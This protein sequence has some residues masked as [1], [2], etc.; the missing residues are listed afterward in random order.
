MWRNG[1]LFRSSSETWPVGG[2]FVGV[3]MQTTRTR[4]QLPAETLGPR[5]RAGAGVGARRIARTIL[6]HL[7]RNR[8]YDFLHALMYFVYAHG[9]LPRRSS[10]LLNDYLFFMK[11][12]GALADPLRQITTDKIYAKYFIDGLAG[13]KVTPETYAVFDS[14]EEIRPGDLPYRCVLKPAHAMNQLTVYL[15]GSDA[16]MSEA[17]YATLRRGL[18]LDGYRQ[19]REANYRHLKPRILCEELI[20]DRESRIEYKLLCYR[21]AVKLFFTA[22]DGPEPGIR[23]LNFYDRRGNMLDVVMNGRRRSEPRPLPGRF[24]EMCEVAERIA[25]HFEFVR[26]D[27][28]LTDKRIYVGELTHC[29]NAANG[30][31]RTLEEEREVSRILFG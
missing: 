15:D 30:R 18:A 4:E 31:F 3:A 22:H 24:A 7:P 1:F 17:D 26:V 6:A 12:G 11:T 27:F 19:S 28:Y 10:G 29:H 16:R 21:G 2:E 13:R 5:L 9:R 14:V 20:G 8:P 23:C 25:A